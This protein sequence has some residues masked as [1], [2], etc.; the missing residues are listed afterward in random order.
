MERERV[1]VDRVFVDSERQGS[2]KAVDEDVN[3]VKAIAYCFCNRQRWSSWTSR[4][5]NLMAFNSW[6]FPMV[7]VIMH[8]EDSAVRVATS[9]TLCVYS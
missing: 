6:M 7:G 3:R 4:T 5:T 8:G 1:I 2:R 9:S